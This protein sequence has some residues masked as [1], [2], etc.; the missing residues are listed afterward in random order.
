[1]KTLRTQSGSLYLA[2]VSSTGDV[3]RVRKSGWTAA[4]KALAV[5]P[6]RLPFL[7]ATTKWL[8][9]GGYVLGYN[10]KGTRTVRLR[11]DQLKVGMVLW[12]PEG[13]ESTTIVEIL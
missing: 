3:L 13:L 10:A 4:R 1:M 8:K 11:P 12:S 9:D 7:K 2:D 5:Y 6:D